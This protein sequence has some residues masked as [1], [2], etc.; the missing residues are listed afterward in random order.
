MG[1]IG[2]ILA[3]LLVWGLG[4]LGRSPETAR[5]MDTGGRPVAMLLIVLLG[6]LRAIR[7]PSVWINLV[8]GAATASVVYF[9]H[10]AFEPRA[11]SGD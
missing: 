9:I 11:N 8:V 3:E 2:A 6:A 1:L 5:W 10:R 4:A 7:P